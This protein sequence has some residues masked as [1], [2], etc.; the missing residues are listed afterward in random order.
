MNSIS[1]PK[2]NAFIDKHAQYTREV[3]TLFAFCLSFLCWKENA[4]EI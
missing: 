1:I 2:K 4:L 3:F